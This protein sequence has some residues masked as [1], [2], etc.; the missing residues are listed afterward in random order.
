MIRYRRVGFIFENIFSADCVNCLA[1]VRCGALYFRTECEGNSNGIIRRTKRSKSERNKRKSVRINAYD[2]RNSLLF[3]SSLL[4][5]G[6]FV[7]VSK[8]CHCVLERRRTSDSHTQWTMSAE[9]R[10]WMCSC[11]L[12]ART[13]IVHDAV[14]FALPHKLVPIRIAPGR[15]NCVEQGTPCTARAWNERRSKKNSISR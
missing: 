2:R 1:I 13:S 6:V 3:G 10:Q 11:A 15:T 9:R 5:L 7:V 4:L 14:H 8:F 12:F